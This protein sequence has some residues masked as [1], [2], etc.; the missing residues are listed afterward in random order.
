M[1]RL[2]K[3]TLPLIM[4]IF[5]VIPVC[6]DEKEFSIGY[7]PIC[8]HF[9]NDPDLNEVN[10]GV[11]VSYDKWVIGTFNNSSYIQSYFLGKKFD[12]KKWKPLENNLYMKLNAHLGLLYGYGE[13][14]PNVSGWSLAAMPTFEIGYKQF[15]IE[16]MV[17]PVDGGVVAC[18]FKYS[19]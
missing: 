19:F 13:H 17:F 6:A 9:N 15:S 3:Y 12:T 18:M 10:H 16:T 2:L 1:K 8:K 11:F 5:L 14:L 4:I 7:V